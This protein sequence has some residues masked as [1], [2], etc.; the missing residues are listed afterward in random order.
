MLWRAVRSSRVTLIGALAFRRRS[1]R[2]RFR[3]TRCRPML[4]DQRRAGP[5]RGHH[6]GNSRQLVVVDVDLGGEILGLA[7]ASAP[8]T[9]R[10]ARRRAHLVIRQDGLLGRLEARQRIRRGSAAHRQIVGDEDAVADRRLSNGSMRACATGLRTKATSSMPA[11][12]MSPTYSPRPRMKRSSSLRR[13]RAPMPWPVTMAASSA[14]E[15]VLYLE[16]VILARED[17][18]RNGWQSFGRVSV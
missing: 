10:R 3:G 17:G 8:R 13:R 12:R 9:S 16:Q 11:S 5:A 2:R 15:V 6:V 18:R 4:V 14:N 1:R 7:R